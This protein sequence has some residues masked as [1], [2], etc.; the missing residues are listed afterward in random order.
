MPAS[1]RI[2]CKSHAALLLAEALIR[3]SID[4]FAVVREDVGEYVDTL[5]SLFRAG[6]LLDHWLRYFSNLPASK[7]REN[8][9]H[10]LHRSAEFMR[11]VICAFVLRDLGSLYDKYAK[12]VHEWIAE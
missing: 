9:L 7:E 2:A 11:T 1:P 8:A 4:C 3:F 6:Q 10:R 12:R 5:A